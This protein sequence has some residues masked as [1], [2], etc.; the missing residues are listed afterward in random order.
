[1][2]KQFSNEN[3]QKEV[4]ESKQ[5]VLVDFWADW[6]GPCKMQGPIVDK[7]AEKFKDKAV[8]GKL[9]VESAGDIAARYGVM[10]IPTLILFKNGEVVERLTGLRKESELSDVI[11]KH[12]KA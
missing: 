4:L 2:A 11:A 6:C 9:D 10:A 1:M 3:F 7:I 12:V 5:P 8:V